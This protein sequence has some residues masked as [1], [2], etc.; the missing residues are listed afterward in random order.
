MTVTPRPDSSVAASDRQRIP[1]LTANA[2]LALV[3]AG[4]VNSLLHESAHA[5]AGLAV[6]LTPTIGPFSVEYAE[7]ATRNQQLATAAAGPL[8]SLVMGLVLLVVACNWGAGF[9]RLFWMWLPA[10]GIMNFV[11]YCFIAPFAQGGDTG[12][13]LALLGTPGWVF[14]LVSMVGV[15][16]QFLLARRFA[17]EVKRY[18]RNRLQEG[19]VAFVSWMIGTP[20]MIVI[21]L[22]EVLLL[23][24]PTLYVVPVLAYSVAFAIFAPM[25]FIF[26]GKG[27][28]RY[29]PL[30]LKTVNPAAI[31]VVA[32]VVIFDILLAA[33][34]GIT[35]G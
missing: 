11:G 15:A 28:N 18:S 20:L 26:S 6:G 31:A 7:A 9:V 13:V 2:T 22:I 8:F 17:R 1:G 23:R 21:T 19:Q 34:G 16:G 5:V 12:R 14:I 24:V 27:A 33:F 3:L 30:V 32:V 4:I 29:E 35:L 10:L 25:Q